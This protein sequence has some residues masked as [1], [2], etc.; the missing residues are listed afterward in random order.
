MFFFPPFF[1]KNTSNF[2]FLFEAAAPRLGDLDGER[3]GDGEMEG[4]WENEEEVDVYFVKGVG[5]LNGGGGG[6]HQPL[7]EGSGSSP[8]SLVDG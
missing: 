6:L 1:P 5:C 7:R 8:P 2:G 3:K 4:D